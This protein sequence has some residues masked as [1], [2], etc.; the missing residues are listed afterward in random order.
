M[1]HSIFTLGSEFESIQH[2]YCIGNLP[3]QWHTKD[4]PTLLSLCHDYYNLVCP[5]GTGKKDQSGDQ[6]VYHIALPS[7]RKRNNG[8][9]IL[10]S[11]PGHG[12][13]SSFDDGLHITF[14]AFQTKSLM[15]MQI[16]LFGCYT[17]VVIYFFSI[18]VQRFM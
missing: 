4:W 3:A 7:R 15:E 1:R 11:N 5:Y 16:Y 12:I 8:F 9:S 2:N 13:Y 17:Y 14:P 10:P 18:F 6:V